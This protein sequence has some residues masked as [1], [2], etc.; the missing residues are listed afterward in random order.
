MPQRGLQ[1]PQGPLAVSGWLGVAARCRGQ[2]RVKTARKDQ[3]REVG[4][5]GKL[6]KGIWGILCVTY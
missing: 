4:L 1:G 3:E 2:S 6:G 5:W